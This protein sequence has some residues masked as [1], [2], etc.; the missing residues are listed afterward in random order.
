MREPRRSKGKQSVRT[1]DASKR[2]QDLP[3]IF[4]RWPVKQGASPGAPAT[5]GICPRANL[6]DC[7]R[8]SFRRE[9]SI[10]GCGA[11]TKRSLRTRGYSR[12]RKDLFVLS[13]TLARGATPCLN[14]S[15]ASPRERYSARADFWP[16]GSEISSDS[17]QL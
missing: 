14:P 11:A 7:A 10:V 8:R 4:P 5:A 9:C 2:P 13:R 6:L 12:V 17:P 3:A 16:G 15:R 1:K